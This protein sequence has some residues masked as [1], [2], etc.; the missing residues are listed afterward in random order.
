MFQAGLKRK[1]RRLAHEKAFLDKLPSAEMYEKSYMHR[2]V[3]LHAIV[4]PV[5]DF[6]VTASTD[7]FVK[8]W[9]KM[10]EGVEFVKQ[11]HAHLGRINALVCSGDGAR[12]CT[13]GA[14][15]SVKFFDVASFDMSN[16]LRLSYVPTAACYVHKRGSPV[17]RVALASLDD[18][19]VRR[20]PCAGRLPRGGPGTH[21]GC[22]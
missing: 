22:R 20:R 5:T 21:G 13:T 2:D 7:G 4:T 19:M 8:F 11:F 14:D 9:K 16:M 10:A 18:A 12:V 15:K 1:K 6:L 17:G 3:V